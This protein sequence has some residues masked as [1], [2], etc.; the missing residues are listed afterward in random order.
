MQKN[1]QNVIQKKKHKC[2]TMSGLCENTLYKS[3]HI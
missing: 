2:G 3:N 1:D